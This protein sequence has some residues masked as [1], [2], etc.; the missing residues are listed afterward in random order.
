MKERVTAH[1]PGYVRHLMSSA[2]SQE[3]PWPFPV[4]G[5]RTGEGEVSLW[6]KRD[7]FCNLQIQVRSKNLIFKNYAVFVTDKCLT[8]LVPV[9]LWVRPELKNIFFVTN[10]CHN[11]GKP[12]EGKH[13]KM[14]KEK[15]KTIEKTRITCFFLFDNFF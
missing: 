6:T 14:A 1:W 7:R 9:F 2:H 11:N 10:D 15:R 12:K 4:L 8:T 13:E 5:W 3:Y